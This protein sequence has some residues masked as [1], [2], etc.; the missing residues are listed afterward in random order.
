MSKRDHELA[1]TKYAGRQSASD[2]ARAA[3]GGSESVREAMTRASKAPRSQ[4]SINRAA[5]HKNSLP[6]LG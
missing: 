1:K 5:R 3:K 2:K 4:E 6:P